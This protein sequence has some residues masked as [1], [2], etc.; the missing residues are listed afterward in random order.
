MTLLFGLVLLLAI[1]VLWKL[2]VDGWLFK[3][4]LFFAG[5]FGLYIGLRVYVEGAKD[6]AF[7]FGKENPITFSW[8]AVIPTA[9]CLLCLLCTKVRD[10]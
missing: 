10:E 9:I 4:I 6:V 5:W 8:A 1:Y 3:I 7:T 2:F